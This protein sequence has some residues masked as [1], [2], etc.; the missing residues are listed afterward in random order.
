MFLLSPALSYYITIYLVIRLTIVHYS[1]VLFDSYMADQKRVLSILYHFF[2]KEKAKSG[3]RKFSFFFHEFIL[4]K[5]FTE[6]FALI[7]C[8]Y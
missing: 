7:P 3:K 8:L 6:F 4:I 5:N 2:L 1:T